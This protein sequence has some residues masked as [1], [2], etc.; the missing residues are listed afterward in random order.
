MLAGY[1]ID[2][3]TRDINLP[4]DS[5]LLF[6]W[7]NPQ[8]LT[9]EK[10]DGQIWSLLI[11]DPP[12]YC[13]ETWDKNYHDRFDY[14][15]SFDETLVDDKKYFYYPFAID[16]EYFSIPDVVTPEEFKERTLA[17][18]VSH[19]IHKF[20]DPNNPGSTLHRR[21]NTIKW[22]G[23]HHPEDFGFYGGTFVPRSY[24]LGFRGVGV[25]KK[26]LPQKSSSRTGYLCAKGSDQGIQR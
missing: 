11:N 6:C 12:M 18:F 26:I 4:E 7:D 1:G 15:F 16:T 17:T 9:S 24:Y 22:Y 13:P 2:I 25:V 20:A 19:A 3:S 23:K 8:S 21:Y 5:F 10:K 14:V